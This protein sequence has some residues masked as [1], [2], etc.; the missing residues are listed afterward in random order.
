M[1][2]GRS[3]DQVSVLSADALASQKA[4][5]AA[6]MKFTATD[7]DLQGTAAANCLQPSNDQWLAGAGTSTV[8]AA[9]CTLEGGRTKSGAGVF[10]SEL[11]YTSRLR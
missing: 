10:V 9:S 4:S 3:V 6:A 2:A 1:V 7:G 8:L 11:M 5:A